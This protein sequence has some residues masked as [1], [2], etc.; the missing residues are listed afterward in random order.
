MLTLIILFPILLVANAIPVAVLEENSTAPVV[1][2][3]LS[4]W[5]IEGVPHSDVWLLPIGNLQHAFFQCQNLSLGLLP[6]EANTI[7]VFEGQDQLQDLYHNPLDTRDIAFSLSPP[8]AP[9]AV[10]ST[11]NFTI[12]INQY[13]VVSDTTHTLYTSPKYTSMVV[14]AID[15]NEVKIDKTSKDEG[16][17]DLNSHLWN[18]DFVFAK[19][20]PK[21][22]QTVRL[23]VELYDQ[24]DNTV[25]R[26]ELTTIMSSTTDS[27]TV[28]YKY[29]DKTSLKK[30]EWYVASPYC[31]N[32]V[33]KV[34]EVKL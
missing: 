28:N 3:Q 8:S 13:D 11:V 2:C 12:I 30:F 20:G 34:G 16:S 23:V 5:D 33:Q 24:K 29:K 31:L 14:P 32:T 22:K 6:Q 27:V 17:Y 21:M 25:F 4:T 26:A 18:Y 1:S 7:V 9:S 15:V 10:N 19:S